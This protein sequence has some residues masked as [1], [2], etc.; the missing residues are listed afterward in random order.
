[1]TEIDGTERF[2][3]VTSSKLGKN[4][5][6]HGTTLPTNPT[7]QIPANGLFLKTDT[8]VLYENTGTESSPTWTSRTQAG[9]QAGDQVYPLNTTSGDYA[10]GT[11]PVASSEGEDLDFSD[12]FATD[13]WNDVGTD[14]GV[15]GGVLNWKMKRE[16]ANNLTWKDLTGA[17]ISDT[18]WFMR[19]KLVI[20]THTAST[21]V[22][23]YV[24]FVMSDNS[25]GGDGTSQDH[26]GMGYV[27][28][29]AD[30]TVF[31][32]DGNGTALDQATTGGFT[33]FGGTMTRYVELERLSAT[34]FRIQIYSDSTFTTS[35]GSSTQTVSSLITNLRYFKLCTFNLATSTYNGVQVGYIDDLQFWDNKTKAEAIFPASN[36]ID[37]NNA[38]KWRS[39][40]E[41]NPNIYFDMGSAK[42][43][44]A[45]ML[46]IDK[47]ITTETVIQIRASTDTT[48]TSGETVRTIL[49]SDFTD[50]TNRFLTIPRAIT[51]KRYVQIYGL[52]NSVVLAI[53]EAK[54]LTKSAADF[55]KGHFHKYL[56]PT[57]TSANTLDSN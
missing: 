52:S 39:F 42:E 22:A 17:V 21:G 1:M 25:T 33:E 7:N 50:D 13:T 55:E 47:T 23:S 14:F 40:T 12:S 54:Y 5:V 6:W 53:N 36:I 29:S 19:F 27:H 15:S 43:F 8:G 31:V 32:A 10:F 38:T 11:S 18:K 20:T 2:A 51:D 4:V 44:H 49:I 41:N 37:G 56:D 16:L 35:T 34:S 46:S 24:W 9:G 28:G 3:E 48:F 26:L 30:Q 45:L 57:S